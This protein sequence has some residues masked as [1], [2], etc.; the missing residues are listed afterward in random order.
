MRRL[1]ESPGSTLNILTCVFLK[2]SSPSCA[3]TSRC[4][5]ALLKGNSGRI[6]KSVKFKCSSFIQEP[7]HLRKKLLGQIFTKCWKVQWSQACGLVSEWPIILKRACQSA[8]HMWSFIMGVSFILYIYIYIV[9]LLLWPSPLHIALRNT[10]TSL[11]A[12]ALF[13][14]AVSYKY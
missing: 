6:Q 12:A 4:N 11:H 3:Q 9:A 10:N 13:S 5:N 8:P 2:W 14:W 1:F 7:F